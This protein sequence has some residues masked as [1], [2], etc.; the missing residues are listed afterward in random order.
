MMYIP[1]LFGRS[2]HRYLLFLN[3][4]QESVQV[5]NIGVA[6]DQ[7]VNAAA[8]IDTLAMKGKQNILTFG[9]RFSLCLCNNPK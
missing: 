9:T 8:L 4:G 7:S 6:I 5:T 1:C 3:T 2:L